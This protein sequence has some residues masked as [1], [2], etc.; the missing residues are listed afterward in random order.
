MRIYILFIFGLIICSNSFA[1]KVSGKVEDTTGVPLG[2]V[3][4]MLNS[5]PE[6]LSTL[7]NNDGFFLFSN[8][9]SDEF[10]LTYTSVGFMEYSQKY[11]RDKGGREFRVDTI[12]LKQK[13]DALSEI[14][15]QKNPI[16]ING[17]Y[18]SI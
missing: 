2:N 10:V 12:H 18:H 6:K 15:I 5:G 13:I 3:S 8:V 17:G 16:T 4:V 9:L 1:Q 7:T 14:I 11:R